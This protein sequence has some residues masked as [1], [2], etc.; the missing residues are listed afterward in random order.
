VADVFAAIADPRRRAVL[1]LLAKGPRNAGSIGDSFPALSQ[2][3]MSRHL[4]VLRTSGLV[5]V[6][7][8]AKQRIYSLRPEGMVD[9]YSWVAR[10]QRQWPDTF[11]S[12]ERYLNA[13]AGSKRHRGSG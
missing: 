1:D 12:L 8:N 9:L 7:V 11:D 5:T 13:R 6:Q 4:K 3:A 2:P 10:Q